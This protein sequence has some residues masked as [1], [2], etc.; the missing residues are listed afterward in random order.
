MLDETVKEAYLPDV[1]IP[2][3]RQSPQHHHWETPEIYG[4]KEELTRLCMV[5]ERGLYTNI[6][7][8]H[9]G[10]YP[11]NTTRQLET[12]RSSPC[13]TYPNAESRNT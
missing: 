1:A 8:I 7:I 3:S 6:S 2:N 11:R 12:A 4:A 5:T 9:N 13:S 10:Y